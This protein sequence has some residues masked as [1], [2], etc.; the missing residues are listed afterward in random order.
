MWSM[1]QFN[2]SAS[3]GCLSWMMMTVYDW[4]LLMDTDCQIL[5]NDQNRSENDG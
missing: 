5:T 1:G 2:S 3:D 4:T